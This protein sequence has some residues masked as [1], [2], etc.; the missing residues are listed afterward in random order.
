LARLTVILFIGLASA[1]ALSFA[2]PDTNA[3][4]VE[5]ASV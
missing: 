3:D 2:R 1:Q 5:P 4:F